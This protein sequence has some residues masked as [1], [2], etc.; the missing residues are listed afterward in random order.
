MVRYINYVF[1]IWVWLD[2]KSN[3]WER[4]LEIRIQEMGLKEEDPRVEEFTIMNGDCLI[5]LLRIRFMIKI[6]LVKSLGD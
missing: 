6:C 1:T 3:L 2:K 4:I 5:F